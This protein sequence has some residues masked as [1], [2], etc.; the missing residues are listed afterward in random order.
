MSGETGLRLNL[1]ERHSE[2]HHKLSWC[3]S[4]PLIMFINLT[5]HKNSLIIEIH[6]TTSATTPD[7]K[8]DTSLLT[9]EPE[10]SPR[11]AE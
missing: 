1:P 6:A 8:T 3:P 10:S 5:L 7:N 4:F 9:L 2:L 11:V